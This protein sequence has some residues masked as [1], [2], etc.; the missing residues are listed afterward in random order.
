LEQATTS[1]DDPTAAAVKA[2][3]IQSLRVALEPLE[4]GGIRVALAG[5][6]VPV[7]EDWLAAADKMMSASPSG[8]AEEAPGPPSEGGGSGPERDASASEAPNEAASGLGPGSGWDGGDYEGI[9]GLFLEELQPDEG[10]FLLA[11][12]FSSYDINI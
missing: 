7:R 4:R 1:L 3:W 6:A 10:N 2:A 12:P 8:S 5:Q 9:L 11:D